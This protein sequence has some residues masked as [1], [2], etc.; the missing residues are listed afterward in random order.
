[1][2]DTDEGDI[3]RKEDFYPILL[4]QYPCL[5]QSRGYHN[6][7]PS[8]VMAPF[9]HFLHPLSQSGPMWVMGRLDWI[10]SIGERNTTNGALGTAK[11]PF[12]WV[13]FFQF[14]TKESRYSIHH[15]IRVTEGDQGRRL[16]S[17]GI[18]GGSVTMCLASSIHYYWPTGRYL[19]VGTR[20]LY[21]R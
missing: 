19:R 2:Q 20:Y 10:R 9:N 7:M 17:D 16:S 13:S 6:M 11:G 1:M 8:L 12:H 15:C 4:W 18:G 14:L 5:Y 3:V 21:H